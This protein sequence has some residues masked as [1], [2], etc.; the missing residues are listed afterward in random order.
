M[1]AL[2]DFLLNQG[3][4]GEKQVVEA[5][6]F[7]LTKV[8][9]S[10]AVIVTPTAALVLDGL[11]THVN[12]RAHHY[13]ALAIGLLGF[14]AIAGAADVL[15]RALVTG[16]EKNAEAANATRLQAAAGAAHLVPF[17][18]P[19]ASHHVLDGSDAPVKVLAAASGDSPYLL[20]QDKDGK[21][22][23]VPAKEVKVGRDD[24]K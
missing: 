19:I 16:A 5:P 14:L 21:I 20:V 18:T 11:E 17:D 1:A 23:W 13:V 9:T 7:S 10:G 2:T 24:L 3:A 12:F 4:N 6:A 15:A 22:T 8:L